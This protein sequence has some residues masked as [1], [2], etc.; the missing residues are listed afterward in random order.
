MGATQTSIVPYQ[1]FR[2]AD[3]MMVIGAPNERLW[4]GFC[5][6]LNRP[7]ISSLTRVSLRKNELRVEHRDAL[8]PLLIEA[9]LIKEPR[10]HWI[11]RFFE[12]RT[13]ALRTRAL[14]R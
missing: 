4:Q 8:I 9:E 12:A 14:H 2:C 5:R 10:R 7:P 1:I 11:C 3:G 13:G 6:A